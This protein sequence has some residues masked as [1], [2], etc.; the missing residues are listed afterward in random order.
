MFDTGSTSSPRLPAAGPAVPGRPVLI[1]TGAAVA[2]AEVTSPLSGR[3][4]SFHL[5]L[6]GAVQ[7]A[8]PRPVAGGHAAATASDG[9][10]T[11]IMS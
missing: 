6:C 4:S 3:G 9:R 2:P 11:R 5:A 7:C 1:G 8:G 10:P